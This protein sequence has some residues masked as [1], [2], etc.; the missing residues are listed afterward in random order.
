MKTSRVTPPSILAQFN[1]AGLMAS[2]SGS[3]LGLGGRSR[4]KLEVGR[5]VAHQA[6]SPWEPIKNPG[7]GLV[8]NSLWHETQVRK[9]VTYVAGLKCYPCSRLLKK[10]LPRVLFPSPLSYKERGN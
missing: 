2:R 7:C 4:A 6:H 8:D 9:T 1:W 3:N 5:R 10:R